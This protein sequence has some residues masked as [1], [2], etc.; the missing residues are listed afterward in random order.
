M[1]N[2]LSSDCGEGGFTLQKMKHL[3]F[4]LLGLII[5]SHI[6]NLAL[7]SGFHPTTV[8]VSAALFHKLSCCRVR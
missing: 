8:T 5:N 7:M 3:Y 1:A 6:L 2:Y 4:N